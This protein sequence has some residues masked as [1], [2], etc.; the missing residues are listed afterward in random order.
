MKLA[1]TPQSITYS[2][3]HVLE[4]QLFLMESHENQLVCTKSLHQPAEL[5]Y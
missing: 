3:H 2:Q 4:A 1:G 5:A